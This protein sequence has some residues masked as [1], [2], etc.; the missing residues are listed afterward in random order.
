M[1]TERHSPRRRRALSKP[2]RWALALLLLL[3]I[4]SLAHVIESLRLLSANRDLVAAVKQQDAPAVRQALQR[5]ADPDLS[6]QADSKLSLREMISAALHRRNLPSNSGRT[7]LTE[8]IARG[9]D[10]ETAKNTE[11]VR[12]LLQ[13]GADPN[14]RSRYYFTPLMTAAIFHKREAARL[15]L[16]HGADPN[17]ADEDGQTPLMSSS[18]CTDLLL[19]HGA[20]VHRKTKADGLTALLTACRDAQADRAVLVKEVRLLL[21]AGADPNSVDKEEISALMTA[22]ALPSPEIVTMLLA[23]GADVNARNAEG[24][25]PLIFAI[26]AGEVENVRLLLKAKADPLRKDRQGLSAIDYAGQSKNPRIIDLIRS[27]IK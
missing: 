13:A 18:D 9:G 24:M 4:L 10:K 21:N 1:E 15:L 20:D 6:E 19:Q 7:L 25:T 16:E 14:R 23:H 2:A 11:I 8:A 22:S 26:G 27:S 5:G 12:L 17:L 3:V